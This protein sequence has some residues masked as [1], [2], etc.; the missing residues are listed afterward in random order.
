[1]LAFV[2][3]A[4]IYIE[5]EK[6]AGA[7]DDLRPRWALDQSTVIRT[8]DKMR[9]FLDSLTPSTPRSLSIRESAKAM[10][11][12]GASPSHVATRQNVWQACPASSST[13]R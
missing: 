13:A 2:F 11:Q 9:K 7:D 3:I 1:M 10:L 12:N 5:D 8:P 6:N 4:W